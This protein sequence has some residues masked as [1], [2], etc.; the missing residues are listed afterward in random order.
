MTEVCD[1]KKL[2]KQYGLVP[3]KHYKLYCEDYDYKHFS[4]Y[5][6]R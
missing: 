5:N 3:G 2:P 1:K 4:V 6:T